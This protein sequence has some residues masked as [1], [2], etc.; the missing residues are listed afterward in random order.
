LPADSLATDE[1]A[2][3]SEAV[4]LRWAT[5]AAKFE[6]IFRA[7]SKSPTWDKTF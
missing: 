7:M 5:F 4:R 1:V 3:E 2:S 6:M